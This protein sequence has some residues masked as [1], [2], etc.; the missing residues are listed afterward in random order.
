MKSFLAAILVLGLAAPEVAS[1]ETKPVRIWNLTAAVILDFR[2]APAGSKAF[3]PNLTK[4][5]KDGEIDIDERLAL[6]ATPPGRYDALIGLKGGRRC[7]VDNL[8]IDAGSIVSI[9]E[10]DLQGC[11]SKK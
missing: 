7:H 10:K 9:E 5:D 11:E 1:A 4:E 6:R 3:G 8:K 2:L